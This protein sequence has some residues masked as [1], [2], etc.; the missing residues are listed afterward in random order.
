M[1]APGGLRG[2]CQ[3]LLSQAACPASSQRL[4]SLPACVLSPLS[5]CGSVWVGLLCFHEIRKAAL[6]SQLCCGCPLPGA[7]APRLLPFVCVCLRRTM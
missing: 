5:R 7:A 3:P 1:P 6:I 4:G 2:A